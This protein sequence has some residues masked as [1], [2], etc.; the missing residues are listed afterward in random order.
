[1]EIEIVSRKENILLNREEIDF[2]AKNFEATP[3]RK[4]LREKIGAIV[5]ADPKNLVVD[6]I[7]NPFGYK[8]IKGKAKVYK[9]EKELEK[10]ELPYIVKRNFPEKKENK[11]EAK[12]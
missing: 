9:N 2:L 7:K 1:M 8:E 3:S 6:I 12:K 11:A 5:N 4:E 10:T